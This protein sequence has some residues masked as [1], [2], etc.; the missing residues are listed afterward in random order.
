MISAKKLQFSTDFS[1]R[2]TKHSSI[3][4]LPRQ[5]WMSYGTGLYSELKYMVKVTK[6]EPPTAYRFSTAEGRTSLFADSPLPPV[7]F[8]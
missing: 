3:I 5:Q 6:F 7:G 8:G 1:Q 4:A 2:Y